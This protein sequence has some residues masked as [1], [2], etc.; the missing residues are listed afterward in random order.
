MPD[1]NEISET[2]ELL[3]A[4]L[5]DEQEK[6]AEVRVEAKPPLQAVKS[7]KERAAERAADREAGR[8]S[9]L[10]ALNKQAQSKGFESVEEMLKSTT[11]APKAKPLDKSAADVELKRENED[12][13]REITGYKRTIQGLR[14][15]IDVLEND[16]ALRQLAYEADIQGDDIDYALTQ[17]QSHYKKLPSEA[18]KDFDPGKYLREDLK[19]KKPGI[20][21]Q[22]LAAKAAEKVVE[23]V[24]VS[25][26]PTGR[27]PK[28]P[29]TKEVQASEADLTRPKRAGDMSKDEYREHLRKLGYRDPA[30]MV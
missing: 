7:S 3:N 15:R 4:V 20:F 29:G 25:T 8:S 27:A 13:R 16:G 19:A 21:R 5:P 11:G 28:G 14:S 6:P 22:A 23:E 30:S 17:L 9:V 26:V 10:D 24:D 18:T 1:D 12:L 2:E